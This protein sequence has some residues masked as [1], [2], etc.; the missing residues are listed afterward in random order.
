MLVV[1]SQLEKKCSASSFNRVHSTSMTIISFLY[2]FIHFST[3][4]QRETLSILFSGQV[5]SAFPPSTGKSYVNHYYLDA[6]PIKMILM[7]VSDNNTTTKSPYFYSIVSFSSLYVSKKKWKTLL[8][9]FD[10]LI[11]SYKF[12]V[13]QKDYTLL[14]ILDFLFPLLLVFF[15]NNRFRREHGKNSAMLSEFYIKPYFFRKSQY[16]I[17]GQKSKF[18]KENN[19]LKAKGSL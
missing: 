12:C 3:C 17:C 4:I 6:I 11:I 16:S 15:E 5:F 19:L 14:N 2:I 9:F 1:Q 10:T 18:K 8:L 7:L 13:F